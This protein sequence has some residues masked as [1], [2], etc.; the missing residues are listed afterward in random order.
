MFLSNK[1]KKKHYTGKGEIKMLSLR[2]GRMFPCHPPLLGSV[3][4]SAG[5]AGSLSALGTRPFRQWH[6]AHGTCRTCL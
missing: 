4:G 3:S 1:I 2:T 5:R 6:P